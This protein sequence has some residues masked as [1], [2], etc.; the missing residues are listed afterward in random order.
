MAG[1]MESIKYWMTFKNVWNV[2]PL[3]MFYCKIPKMFFQNQ[4]KKKIFCSS[5]NDTKMKFIR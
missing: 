2:A 1:Y 5:K 4:Q 3:D